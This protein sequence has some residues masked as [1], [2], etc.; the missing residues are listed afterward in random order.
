MISEKDLQEAIAECQG[1]RNPNAN[2]CIKLAAYYTILQY[3]HKDE[4]M[5]SF[6]FP[7]YS[8]ASNGIEINVAN[9]FLD[10]LNGKDPKAV[11]LLIAEFADTISVIEPKLYRAMLQKAR[12]IP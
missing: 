5:Q 12:E 2:T 7:H 8:T 6:E 10:E 3:M 1:V 4:T 11:W 9:P